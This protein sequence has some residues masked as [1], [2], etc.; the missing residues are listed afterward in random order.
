MR[1]VDTI[2]MVFQDLYRHKL[3]TLMSLSGVAWGSYI[4]LMLL[5]LGQGFYQHQLNALSSISKPVLTIMLSNTSK[6]YNGFAAN[7]E[8]GLSPRQLLKLQSAMTDIASFTPLANHSVQF[9]TDKNISGNFLL[10]GIS[11]EFFTMTPHAL[12]GRPL[13]QQDMK[14]A[15]SVI[16]LSDLIK[17]QLF[18]NKDPI[19]KTVFIDHHAFT[20][21]AYIP[22]TQNFT[23]YSLTA[24]IPFTSYSKLYPQE[25][26]K[27]FQVLLKNHK[28]SQLVQANI[29]TYLAHLLHFSPTDTQV[30]FNAMDFSSYTKNTRWMLRSTLI[31]LSFCGLMTLTVGGISVAN[32]MALVTKEQTSQIGLQMALGAQPSFILKQFLIQSFIYCAIGG[33]I[34]ILLSILTLI[35]L[36]QFTLPDWIGNPSIPLSAYIFLWLSLFLTGFLAGH[37]SAKRA[38]NMPPIQALNSKD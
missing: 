12:K 32:M 10:T 26:T 33:L 36:Q 38:A 28:D 31:F 6:P 8:I 13:N 15:R 24:F 1:L 35:T 14:H 20:V 7:R 9:I 19:G 22:Q 5:G 2:R 17:E 37:P 30:V 27:S 34:G 18:G 11:P 23:P 25:Q 16:V 3:R 29:T 21:I 4:I